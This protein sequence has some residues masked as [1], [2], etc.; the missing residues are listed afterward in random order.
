MTK[1]PVGLFGLHILRVRVLPGGATFI[2]GAS[3]AVR[4]IGTRRGA[5][6]SKAL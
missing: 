4:S 3:S 2:G 5:P 1:R 6:Q